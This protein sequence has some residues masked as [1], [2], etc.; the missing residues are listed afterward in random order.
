MTTTETY[1]EQ[2]GSRNP[3]SGYL[4]NGFDMYFRGDSEYEARLRNGTMVLLKD[5]YQV[6]WAKIDE[7]DS[8]NIEA[9]AIQIYEDMVDYALDGLMFS[10]AQ[11]GL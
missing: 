1:G 4:S 11:G 2:F 10:Q 5:T 7:P 9:I 3:V 8:E 6:D